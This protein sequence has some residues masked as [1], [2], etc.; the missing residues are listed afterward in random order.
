MAAGDVVI[1]SG[2]RTP[3]GT[4]GGA[5]KDVSAVELGTH[6]GARGGAPRRHRAR[7]Q[8]DEVILGCILQAGLGMNPARQAAIK[9]GIPEVGARAH[10]EQGLRLRPEGGDA[11]R[12]GDQGRATPRWWWPAAPRA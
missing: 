1:L 6:R 5:F 4:F 12:A 3:I 11:G 8:V 10:R 2:C 7:T 9:A